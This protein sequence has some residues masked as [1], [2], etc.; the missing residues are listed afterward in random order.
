LKISQRTNTQAK[1]KLHGY[2]FFD[3]QDEVGEVGGIVGGEEGQIK[4]YNREEWRK[5]LRTARN[6]HILHMAME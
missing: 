5:L 3:G 2:E 1:Q 6:S 4:V